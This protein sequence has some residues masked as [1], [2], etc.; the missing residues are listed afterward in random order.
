MSPSLLTQTIT[1]RVAT[2]T[3]D[4]G[5]REPAYTET[6]HRAAVQPMRPQKSQEYGI[7]AGVTAYAVYLASDPGLGAGDRVVWRGKTLE[8]L[9]PAQDQAGLGRVFMVPCREVS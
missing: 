2:Y 5:R 6:D 9:G 7:E 3:T 8:V 4:F 1:A